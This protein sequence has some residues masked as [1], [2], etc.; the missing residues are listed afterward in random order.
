MNVDY[1]KEHDIFKI[2]VNDRL[3]YYNDKN[4]RVEFI[5]TNNDK[6]S[7]YVL[8]REEVNLE[9]HL[10]DKLFI[11]TVPTNNC[12]LDCKYCYSKFDRDENEDL[13]FEDIKPLYDRVRERD[14]EEINITFTGGG[15]PTLNFEFI[16]KTVDYFSD[17]DNVSFMITTNGVF[18][19]KV[20]NFLID[21]NFS[22]ALSLD[23]SL[24]QAD[25]QQNLYLFKD[26]YSRTLANAKRFRKS[27][28]KISLLS[29]VT[30][31]AIKNNTEFLAEIA[32]YFYKQQFR[33]FSINF[34][35][36][37]F[38][39]KLT[40]EE[41]KLITESCRELI[42]W[43]KDHQSVNVY[44]RTILINST[45]Y[46]SNSY[47]AG[48]FIPD[49]KITV[50][51]GGDLSFCHRVQEGIYKA[52]DERWLRKPMIDDIDNSKILKAIEKLKMYNS[53][54][55]SCISREI[56]ETHFCPA[57]FLDSDK[58]E[59]KLDNYCNNMKVIRKEL[60]FNQIKKF[61]NT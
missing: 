24:E 15:E 43:K 55:K 12:Q 14:Y 26:F 29:V 40:V 25:L 59:N 38:Y 32:D 8:E 46:D 54:C 2:N 51:P 37:I 21:N 50:L 17:S 23:G 27:D 45:T 33:A 49:Y 48:L 19:K 41:L 58:A 5:E 39:K 20:C 22:V 35:S 4:N 44:N 34:D 56:C 3:M 13:K 28:L 16:E 60:I 57:V 30:L 7:L 1:L 47:C 18:S 31:D 53:K 42:N 11:T 9:Q 61:L 52:D 6:P 10:K 36:D